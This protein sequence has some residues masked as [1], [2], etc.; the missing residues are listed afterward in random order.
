VVADLRFCAVH[1]LRT[2]KSS[3]LFGVGKDAAVVARSIAGD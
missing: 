2:R 3:L 1:F